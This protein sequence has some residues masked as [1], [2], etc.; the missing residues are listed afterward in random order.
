MVDR[1]LGEVLEEAVADATRVVVVR[2]ETYDERRRKANDLLADV[3]EVARIREL[4]SALDAERTEVALM[5]RGD[6]TIAFLDDRRLLAA[7]EC[8]EGIVR[9]PE[10]WAHDA[11]LKDP[12]KLRAW[13]HAATSNDRADE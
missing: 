12:A 6:R 5:M 2:G 10:L 3:R 11:E 8:L 9:C 13:L 7:V 4:I 1:P